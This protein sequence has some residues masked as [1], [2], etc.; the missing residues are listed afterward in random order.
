M[1]DIQPAYSKTPLEEIQEEN[2]SVRSQDAKDIDLKAKEEP[3]TADKKK[4]F[5]SMLLSIGMT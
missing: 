3:M 1:T 2:L 4:I 5:I